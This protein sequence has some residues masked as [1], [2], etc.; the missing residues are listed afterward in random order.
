MLNNIVDNIEQYRQHNNLFN[1]S[2]FL[3]SI[4]NASRIFYCDFKS[5]LWE[6]YVNEL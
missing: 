1:N 3:P 6:L 2:K 4:Y 5:E